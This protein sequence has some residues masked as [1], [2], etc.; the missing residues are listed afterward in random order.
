MFA[1][2]NNWYR[3]DCV[4]KRRHFPLNDKIRKN[5]KRWGWGL[6]LEAPLAP[7]GC[8]EEEHST[9]PRHRQGEHQTKLHLT[10]S[11]AFFPVSKGN[12]CLH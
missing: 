7:L 9:R 2:G 8:C 12:N 6:L 1:F 4:G 11:L 3:A 5:K 10:L